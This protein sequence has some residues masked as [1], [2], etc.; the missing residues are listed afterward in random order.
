MQKEV[1]EL[2]WSIYNQGSKISLSER[3]M[4]SRATY[5]PFI[6][7]LNYKLGGSDNRSGQKK[8]KIEG[9]RALILT[10]S[11]FF[12]QFKTLET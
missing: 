3:H 5:N 7:H 1:E 11:S 9:E 2:G 12:P 6:W 8:E 4:G 10:A